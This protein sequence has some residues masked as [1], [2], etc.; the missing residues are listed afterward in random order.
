MIKAIN[1][2]YQR[3]IN[4]AYKNSRLYHKHVNLDGT[5]NTEKEQRASERKV[6]KF[7]DVY[8]DVF[9]S[10]PQREQLNFNKA[11]KALHGYEG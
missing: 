4:K 11:Y 9:Y 7:Y 3:A 6:E 5:F 10:L 8:F 2:K 1:K